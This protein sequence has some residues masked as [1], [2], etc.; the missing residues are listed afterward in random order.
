M[1]QD[2]SL[3]I[4]TI[5]AVLVLYLL[6]LHVVAEDGADLIDKRAVEGHP[7]TA[8]CQVLHIFVFTIYGTTLLVLFQFG[9][10][11]NPFVAGSEIIKERTGLHVQQ[12]RVDV[13]D[14]TGGMDSFQL[15]D[16]VV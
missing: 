10:E 2:V 15:L 3:N 16:I 7:V 5:W 12:H 11:I 14:K 1:P 8:L 6:K 13:D 9:L 4:R